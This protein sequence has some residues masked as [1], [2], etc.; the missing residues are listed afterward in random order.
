MSELLRL[1]V[2]VS[3]IDADYETGAKKHGMTRSVRV[4]VVRPDGDSA[5]FF[6]KAP[7]EALYGETLRSDRA[8]ELVW[9]MEGYPRIPGH[10]KAHAVSVEGDRL[11]R[12]DR[13]VSNW[14]LMEPEMPG[15]L[16]ADRLA[17]LGSGLF[18]KDPAVMAAYL[19]E[20]HV[21][22]ED[23]GTLYRRSIRDTLSNAT[24][25]LIDSSTEHWGQRPAVHR[26]L[27]HLLTDWRIRL[28]G[29]GRLHRTHHDFHPWNIF[30]EGDNLTVTGA[31]LPG[32]GDV[33]DDLA[34]LLV[35]YIWFSL[36]THRAF[37][38]AYR[39]AYHD[40]VQTYLRLSGNT[41]A[42]ASY[43]PFLAKRLLVLINPAYYPRQP[44]W[45]VDAL[46]D[47]TMA[48]LREEMDALTELDGIATIVGKTER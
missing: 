48:V 4:E 28:P 19:A 38:G 15:D 29:N 13:P 44:G 18:A 21:P 25:R 43:P 5:A 14:C 42:R 35:N 45:I 16:L 8:R 31:R 9:R 40:T 24:F 37:E 27:E 36:R 47:L 2:E 26:E 7:H 20:L 41:F 23:D 46:L 11:V 33:S 3:R 34:A 39:Q 6:L 17:D 32:V 30:L 10:V 12:V 1:P 22:V